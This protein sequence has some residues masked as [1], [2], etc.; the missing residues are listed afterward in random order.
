MDNSETT[1]TKNQNKKT[2][3]Q[4]RNHIQTHT[5]WN[6]NKQTK[7]ENKTTDITETG[8]EPSLFPYKTPTVLL[9][10]RKT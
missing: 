1:R 3:T 2:H 8:G 6:K 9:M 7:K 10:V 4:H 5:K